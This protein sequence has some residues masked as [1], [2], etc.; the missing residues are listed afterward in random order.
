M[1]IRFALGIASAA[2]A[3]AALPATAGAHAYLLRVE[4]ADRSVLA[5]APHEVRLSFSEPVRPAPGIEAIRNGGGSVLRGKPRPEGSSLVIP[6]RAGLADGA[7]TVRW[8]VIS[9]DGHEVGGVLAFGVGSGSAPTPS[10][11]AGSTG[12]G[13]GQYAARWLFFI[14][15]LVAAGSAVFHLLVWRPGLADSDLVPEERSRA[16]RRELEAGSLLLA[17][18]FTAA[19]AGAL[20]LLYL[21]HAGWDTRFGRVLEIGLAI[22]GV[23]LAA[24]AGS[25]VV[26]PVRVVALL[27]GLAVLPIPSLAG[28]ALDHGRTTLDLVVDIAHVTAAAVWIGGVLTVA[29]VLPWTRR[30]TARGSDGRLLLPVARRF[31]ML[32]LAAVIVL[33]GTGVGRALE[34]LDSVSQLWTTGYGRAILVKT[35][36]LAVLILV[37]ARNRFIFLSGPFSRLWRGV[38]AESAVLLGLVVAVAVLTALPPGR[39]AAAATQANLPPVAAGPPV[40]PPPGPLVLAKEDGKLAVGLAAEPKPGGRTRLTATILGSDNTGVGGLGV[41]FVLRGTA[42]TRLESASPCGSGCYT[43]VSTNPGKPLAVRVSLAGRTSSAVRFQLPARW[44]APPAAALLR[45]ATR[46]YKDLRSISYVERL[47]SGPGSGVTSIWKE[48]A[49]D[50]F[51]YRIPGGA[52]GIVIGGRRWDRSSASAEWVPSTLQPV[53]V[54]V[55]IWGTGSRPTNVRLLSATRSAVT[56]SFL[57]RSLPAW[58]RVRFDRR[59]LRP[60]SL[61]MTAA[62]HFMHHVF[63]SFDR[64]LRIV[65]PS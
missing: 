61:E 49:P 42:G 7:Y 11:S 59:R 16:D 18:G 30:G 53:R 37:A 50:R 35:G 43:A 62:A 20:L 17:A 27:A 64:P 40:L 29:A 24:A 39:N 1:R 4:P 55:P 9:D 19:I 2:L 44:P 65:P 54:P 63:R 6:L 51:S 46:A 34:E 8:R 21:S 13:A 33:A 12:A 36:L 60:F 58:F 57:D 48:V 52:A 3:A 10:L 28:H 38:A 14:G 15:L 23:G 32:A 26:R 22:A 31:S 41:T 5:R 45:R 25:L 47:S 56:V